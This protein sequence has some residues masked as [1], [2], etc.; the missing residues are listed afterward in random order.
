MATRTVRI[1]PQVKTASGNR[2]GWIKKVEAVDTSK[3]DGYAFE[4][5]F[6]K[7]N[8]ETDIEVGGIL[9]RVDPEDS[10][11]RSYKTGHVLRVKPDGET[12][13]LTPSNLDWRND[14]LTTRDMAW[15]ALDA[16]AALQ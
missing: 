16:K 1:R 6:L 8:V 5:E 9:L 10:A 4:G 13:E 15:Q 12:E 2:K 11:R 3:K 7:E 14:F